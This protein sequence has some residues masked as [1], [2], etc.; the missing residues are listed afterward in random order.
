MQRHAGK[1]FALPSTLSHVHDV[2]LPRCL[3]IMLQ[4]L[5]S[6]AQ[7]GEI[8][9]FQAWGK[10]LNLAVFGVLAFDVCTTPGLWPSLIF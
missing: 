5:D 10:D 2:V 7:T 6:A 9:D 1:I 8:I 3:D 4:R